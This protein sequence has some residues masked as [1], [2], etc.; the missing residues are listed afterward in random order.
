MYV[1]L[2]K[3]KIMKKVEKLTK[4][5]TIG[6]GLPE[7]LPMIGIKIERSIWEVYMTMEIPGKEKIPWIKRFS[8][9]S[10]M[11]SI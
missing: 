1:C 5:A 9:P 4:E 2:T 6:S 10:V 3:F 8:Q 7:V 11:D